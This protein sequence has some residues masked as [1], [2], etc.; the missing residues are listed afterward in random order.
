MAENKKNQISIELSEEIAQGTY[1]NLAIIAHSPSEFVVDFVQVLPGTPKA[2]VKSRVI[3]TPE[4]AKKLLS[5]L[6]DN[7]VKYEKSF[8]KINTNNGGTP[9]IPIT[10]GGPMVKA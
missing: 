4:N 1:S 7:I 2:K 10:F 9:N 6:Q 5:A 3:M 8:G